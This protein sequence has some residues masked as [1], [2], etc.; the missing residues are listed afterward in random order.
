MRPTSE[1][2]RLGEPN[3]GGPH[4]NH[5]HDRS[6]TRPRLDAHARG[7]GAV[8]G[9]GVPGNGHVLRPAQLVPAGVLVYRV[10]QQLMGRLCRPGAVAR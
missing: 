5:P 10:R 6:G 4:A 2:G 1:T 3:H 9:A 8:P 7:A